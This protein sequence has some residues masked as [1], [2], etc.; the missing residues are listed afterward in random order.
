MRVTRDFGAEL[1]AAARR[2]L[3]LGLLQAAAVLAVAV[4]LLLG[5]VGVVGP[6]VGL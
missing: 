2:E 1:R 6:A 5:A 4:A 3:A